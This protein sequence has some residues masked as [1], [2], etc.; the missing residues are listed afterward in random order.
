MSGFGYCRKCGQRV[1]L[2]SEGL[3][4]YHLSHVADPFNTCPGSQCEPSMTYERAV[5]LFGAALERVESASIRD[6]AERHQD[7]WCRILA[8]GNAHVAGRPVGSDPDLAAA[9]IVCTA[10]GA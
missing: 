5:S 9:Y 10:M 4:T 3:T 2:T 1:N 8:S 7:V 6:W